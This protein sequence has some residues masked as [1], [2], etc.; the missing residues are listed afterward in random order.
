MSTYPIEKGIPISKNYQNEFLATIASMEVAD[1]FL[2]KYNEGNSRKQGAIVRTTVNYH[3]RHTGKKFSVKRQAT[4]I[5]V[6]RK[7]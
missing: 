3:T 6:W 7:K 4:G 5:R 1:S 2:V